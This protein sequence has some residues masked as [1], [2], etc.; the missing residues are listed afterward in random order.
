MV[1]DSGK[2]MAQIERRYGWPDEH[3]FR[4]LLYMKYCGYDKKKAQDFAFL[5]IFHHLSKSRQ[6]KP[7]HSQGIFP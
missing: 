3:L 6:N 2:I 1:T 4:I 7:F 5:P